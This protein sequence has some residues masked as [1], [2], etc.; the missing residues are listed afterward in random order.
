MRGDVADRLVNDHLGAA[1]F[2]VA[3]DDTAEC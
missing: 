3:G 1:L 2:V